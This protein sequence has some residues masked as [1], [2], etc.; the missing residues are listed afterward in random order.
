MRSC[1]PARVDDEHA[2]DRALVILKRHLSSAHRDEHTLRCPFPAVV[3]EVGTTVPEYRN[4][5]GDCV[6]ALAKNIEALLP[7]MVRPNRRT[8]FSLGVVALMCSRPHGRSESSPSAGFPGMGTKEDRPES[9]RVAE[10]TGL[11]R[12][13]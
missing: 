11:S 1:Q 6:D 9:Q 10:P 8:A 12:A 2:A 4:V 7:Q 13:R 5:L 3:G